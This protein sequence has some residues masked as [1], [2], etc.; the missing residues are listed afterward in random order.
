MMERRENLETL[1]VKIER[2]DDEARHEETERR[3]RERLERDQ[4]KDPR[5][6][7]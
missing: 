3:K 5:G 2:K 7:A 1:L 4:R 6:M